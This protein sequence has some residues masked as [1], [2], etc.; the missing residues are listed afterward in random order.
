MKAE[1]DPHLARRL[2]RAG[3]LLGIACLVPPVWRAAARGRT[4]DDL[5][6]VGA[7]A[8]SALFALAFTVW[9]SDRL[10]LGRR[11]GREIRRGNPAAALA[12]GAHFVASSLVAG[13]C[14]AGDD[15]TLLPVSWA[16]FAIAQIALQAMIALFRMLTAY[17]D[18][19]EIAGENLAAAASY[20]GVAV[21]LALIVSHAADGPFLG[22]LAA[23]RGFGLSLLLALAL[24]PVRQVIVG[25]LVLGCPLVLRGGA[26]DRAV[27]QERDLAS[28]IAEAA[29]YVAAALLATGIA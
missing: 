10:L 14:F 20:G 11:L 8:G 17:E 3:R 22:W 23:L 9:L 1:H 18:G 25:R 27:C 7:F 21:A 13:R 5:A 28:A 15:L 4:L 26:L 19:E 2:E 29:G 12:A 16:F 6:V 24:Y